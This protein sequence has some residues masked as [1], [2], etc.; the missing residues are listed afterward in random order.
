MPER[1]NVA[2]SGALTGSATA[3]LVFCGAG[4]ASDGRAVG[5]ATLTMPTTIT[6]AAATAMPTRTRS[7]L[8][9]VNFGTC[10]RLE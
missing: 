5:C 3:T 10:I 9:S 8:F 6:T 2:L 4:D 7:G 1:R